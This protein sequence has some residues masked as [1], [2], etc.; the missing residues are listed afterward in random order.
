MAD[1]ESS[2]SAGKALRGKGVLVGRSPNALRLGVDRVSAS[3]V[4]AE[5]R[6][7]PLLRMMGVGSEFDS[8]LAAREVG[9]VRRS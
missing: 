2:A 3:S 5:E 6:K 8:E 1:S 9:F 4:S 7:T